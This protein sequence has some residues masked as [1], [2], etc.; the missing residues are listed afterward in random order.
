[1]L[2][3]QFVV[4]GV[5]FNAWAGS[6]YVI[7]TLRGTAKPNRVTWLV[8][9]V[10]GWIAFAAQVGQGIIL[11]AL[12]TAVVALVPTAIFVA[13]LRSSAEWRITGLESSCLILCGI[14]LA[15]LFFTSG[16]LSVA[17]SILVH[18]LAAI[19]T[20]RNVIRSPESEAPI[21]Y[22]AGLVNA[23]CTLGALDEWTFGTSAFAVYFF[24]LCGSITILLWVI[25]RI[26]AR[27]V[28]RRSRD[29][30]SRSGDAKCVAGTAVSR[31]EQVP[32]A[33]TIG[34]FAACFAVD[35]M[36]FDECDP[37][38]RGRALAKYVPQT[39]PG[40][41][42]KV[43]WA[44]LGRQRA[45]CPLYGAVQWNGG[46]RMDV[47]VRLRLIPYR[48]ID[49]QSGLETNRPD[50]ES[51][52]GAT[53]LH[54][55]SVTSVPHSRTIGWEECQGRWVR[56]AITVVCAG[57]QLSVFLGDDQIRLPRVAG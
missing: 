27:P 22:T 19:P 24:L 43:G 1:M 53:G 2:S 35:Y 48:R 44:G 8:W 45:V 15:L 32:S 49:I 30:W 20:F 46:C 52:A 33:A 17:V 4:V 23:A 54:V 29:L 50:D 7:A 6:Q 57:E 39:D 10:A 56:M 9:G 47:D 11:P 25:P 3:D 38:R 13:S 41:L 5:I 18:A 36:S 40:L 14:A 34:A 55:G 26:G 31:E 16:D 28:D 42:M 37:R 21:A 12:L 51:V